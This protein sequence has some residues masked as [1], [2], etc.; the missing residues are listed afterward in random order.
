MIE[1]FGDLRTAALLKGWH[2][3]DMPRALQRPAMVSLH[4]VDAADTVDDLKAAPASCPR[5]LSGGAPDS[6]A[7]VLDDGWRLRFV[8]PEGG[9]C[10][11]GSHPAIV[12]DDLDRELIDMSSVTDGKRIEPVHPGEI[13]KEQFLDPQDI[14]VYALSNAIKVPRS[15]TNDIVL[16]RRAIT[17][18]TAL[19][20][21][22]YFGTSAEFWMRLQA[23][24]DLDVA[25]R[26][27]GEEI[28]KDV[29]SQKD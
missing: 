14:S 23:H 15:R 12:R 10:A 2:V 13:L 9:P 27:D 11:A 7:I 16:G 22:H 8:W 4:M 25:R 5:A 21:A 18:D 26:E 19:R 29:E 3:T 28:A 1:S 20:L 17:A 6:W 24:H